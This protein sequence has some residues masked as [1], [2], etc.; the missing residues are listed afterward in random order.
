[1]GSGFNR[2][3]G[4]CWASSGEAGNGAGPTM[5][6]DVVRHAGMIVDIDSLQCFV[7]LRWS[8]NGPSVSQ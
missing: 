7:T 6:L 3:I 1:M 5:L 8:S 4:F 2:Y